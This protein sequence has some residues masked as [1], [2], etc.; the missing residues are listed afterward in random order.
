MEV[1]RENWRIDPD[2]MLRVTANIIKEG[3][4]PYALGAGLKNLPEDMQ[5]RF[6]GRDAVFERITFDALTD[7]ILASL[8]GKPVLVD[9]H[10]WQRAGGDKAEDRAIGSIAGKP[11]IVDGFVQ[12]DLLITDPETIERI[13]S[14]DLMEISAGYMA[15]IIDQQGELDGKLYDMEQ[16]ITRFNHVTILPLGK[17]RCGR[18]VKILNSM[19]NEG[20]NMTVKI[21]RQIGNS[22]ETFSFGSDED[23]REAR[24]MCDMLVAPVDQRRQNAE[25]EAAGK[26]GEIDKLKKE[27][28]SLAGEKSSLEA[29]LDEIILRLEKLSALEVREQEAD[30]D[31]ILA[32]ELNEDDSKKAKDEVEKQNSLDGR[33]KAVVSAVARQNGL[34]AADWS[35]DAVDSQFQLLAARAKKAKESREAAGPRSSR[36]DPPENGFQRTNAASGKNRAVERAKK[37]QEQTCK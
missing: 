3:V 4:F 24:R 14:R 16:D 28:E 19:E 18:D 7:E 11:K 31:V 29:K 1:R 10:D 25:D 8:E 27:N 37:R 20:N 32:E 13:R 17:G 36:I 26:D 30:E 22:V 33:R 5:K 12:A 9:D 35:T 6:A 21:D 15:G 23:A 34:D 2:G